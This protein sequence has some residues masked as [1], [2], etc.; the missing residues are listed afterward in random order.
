MPPDKALPCVYPAEVFMYRV[1]LG[2]D[3][4]RLESGRPLVIG[5]VSIPHERGA[6]AHSDGDVLL[7]A[8]IDALLGAAGMGDIGEWFPD[9]DPQFADADSSLLLERVVEELRHAGW[10]TV[11]LDCTV[12]AQRP[13]LSSYKPLMAARIAE[14]VGIPAERVN[15]KAKTGESVGPVG[16]QEAVSA[17]AVAL[18]EQLHG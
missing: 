8:V 17:D 15:V 4:H 11:N 14:L 13:K 10:R 7:H 1:G 16:R 18:I 5:G 6:V 2:H 12:F 3:T 9:N